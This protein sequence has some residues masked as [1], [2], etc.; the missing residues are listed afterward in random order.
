MHTLSPELLKRWNAI[1]AVS[2]KPDKTGLSSNPSPEEYRRNNHNPFS[3]DLES[4]AN[5]F[6]RQAARLPVQSNTAP[7]EQNPAES[8]IYTIGGG[9]GGGSNIYLGGAGGYSGAAGNSPT[10][11]P[12]DT[13]PNTTSYINV[14]SPFVILNG[15]PPQSASQT[16]LPETE[17]LKDKSKYTTDQ[18]KCK[19][20][21]HVILYPNSKNLKG[22]LFIRKCGAWKFI[23]PESNGIV[24]SGSIGSPM[25][26]CKILY[27]I[28]SNE[29][30]PTQ[31]PTSRFNDLIE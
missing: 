12:Q 28:Y 18:L 20:I 7:R 14:A 30:E 22:M 4:N 3:F 8:Y 15:Q 6:Y 29:N 10:Y 26:D 19:L 25:P 11:L 13:N 27:V 9:G 2:R 21:A 1:K 23:D 16:I 17:K 5:Y 24:E 31:K